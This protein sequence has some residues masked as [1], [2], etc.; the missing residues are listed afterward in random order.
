MLRNNLE[1]Y[2]VETDARKSWTQW[3][4]ITPAL[5]KLEDGIDNRLR[6]PKEWKD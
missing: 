4:K 1:S 3:P 6:A 5:Y 2:L